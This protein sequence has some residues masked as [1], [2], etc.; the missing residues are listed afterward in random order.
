MKSQK[1]DQILFIIAIVMGTILLTGI[2]LSVDFLYAGIQERYFSSVSPGYVP[3]IE[4][5]NRV[6]I[7]SSLSILLGLALYGLVV[8]F[9]SRKERLANQL[10]E[11]K[12]VDKAGSINFRAFQY[13]ISR[14]IRVLRDLYG[15]LIT[16]VIIA[17]LFSFLRFIWIWLKFQTTEGVFIENFLGN[18]STIMVSLTLYLALGFMI[19]YLVL[20]SIQKYVRL[21]IISTNYEKAMEQMLDNL[22]VLMQEEQQKETEKGN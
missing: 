13:E 15:Y 10:I 7:A 16:I 22:D 19:T 4:L 18:I 12:I 21:Q 6:I 2:L 17:A 14:S 5:A 20:V 1:N 9:I 8:W 3:N 11:E